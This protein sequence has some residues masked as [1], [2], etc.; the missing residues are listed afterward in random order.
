MKTL[1]TLQTKT[2][3]S[4]SAVLRP[5]KWIVVEVIHEDTTLYQEP[6]ETEKGAQHEFMRCASE[7][8]GKPRGVKWPWE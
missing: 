6:C 5:D 1:W 2:G 7:F 3:L 8:G 4:V